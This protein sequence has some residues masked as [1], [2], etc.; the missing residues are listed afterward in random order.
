MLDVLPDDLTATEL[1][2]FPQVLLM[3]ADHRLAGR[4]SVTLGDLAGARLV[5]P[6]QPR[7]HRALLERALRV[8]GANGTVA[9]EAEGWP[10][11][12]HFVT[13]GVGLA[14]VNGCVPAPPGLVAR[15]V[16]DLPPVT[17]HVVH[18]PAALSD[19]RVATLLERLLPGRTGAGQ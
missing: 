11:I 8:A 7:P 16:A 18:R 9:V 14:I 5:V 6:P 3:P 4:D 10:L 15:P 2:S 12:T 19:L 1:A 17:Y 13:L